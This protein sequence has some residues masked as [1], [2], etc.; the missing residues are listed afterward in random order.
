M[1][2]K[3]T[4]GIKQAIHEATLYVTCACIPDGYKPSATFE[5]MG[6]DA[7]TLINLQYEIEF[8]LDTEINDIEITGEMTPDG[9]VKLLVEKFGGTE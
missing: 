1:T 7:G 5:T 8:L 2:T 6:L 9:L 3:K 4:D